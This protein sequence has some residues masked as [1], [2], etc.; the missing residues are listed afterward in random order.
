[1]GKPSWNQLLLAIKRFRIQ[2][3]SHRLSSLFYRCPNSVYFEKIGLIREPQHI[4]IG[5]GVRFHDYIYLTVWGDS[6][7]NVIIS[8][9]NNCN[10]GA[11]NH[12]TAINHIEIGDN[13]LTGKWVTIT[14]NNHG[15][16]DKEDLMLPPIQRKVTSSGPVIIGKN[17]WI[18]EKSTILSGVT[19]G[20][21]A[22]IAANSVV[23]H[24]IPAFAVAAGIPA[25]VIKQL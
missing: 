2:L 16:T 4:C 19:I 11:F 14:D 24:N 9:G 15:T 3:R 12:I 8:I 25:K 18:G 5:N 20:D 7:E 10:F 13:C 22:V 6:P 23:T 17:V 21:G 1:M